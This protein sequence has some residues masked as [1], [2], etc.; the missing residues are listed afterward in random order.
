MSTWDEIKNSPAGT[1]FTDKDGDRWRFTET[2]VVS[3]E[4]NGLASQNRKDGA[5]WFFGKDYYGPYLVTEA[6]DTNT[7]VPDNKYLTAALVALGIDSDLTASAIR[8]ILE[9]A[10]KIEEAT[11]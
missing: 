9:T 11:K 8:R 2:E 3:L 6:R 5:D 1:E 10:R 4:N 7:V